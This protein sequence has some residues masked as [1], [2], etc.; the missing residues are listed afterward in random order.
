MKPL[1]GVI[2]VR[3]A[4][5]VMLMEML[6]SARFRNGEAASLET[7]TGT[8][9]ANALWVA[10]PLERSMR[11]SVRVAPLPMFTESVKTASKVPSGVSAA[12]AVPTRSVRSPAKFKD[13][14]PVVG[15]KDE[16]VRT[17]ISAVGLRLPAP[18]TATRDKV[19]STLPAILVLNVPSPFTEAVALAGCVTL[20]ICR[21]ASASTDPTSPCTCEKPPTGGSAL[22]RLELGAGGGVR[23]TTI[24]RVAVAEFPAKSKACA[25][26]VWLPS[27]TLTTLSVAV[28]GELVLLITWPAKVKSTRCV[29]LFVVAVVVNWLLN[30]APEAGDVNETASGTLS[31]TT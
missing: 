13:V 11:E 21:V 22:I 14:L 7:P 27:G 17:E 2:S 29:A 1:S 24:G 16:V 5:E 18:S 23:S 6:P 28:K 25:V 31:T 4:P 19:S 3:V 26:I 15:G 30:G 20:V 12:A 10:E 9:P 8:E